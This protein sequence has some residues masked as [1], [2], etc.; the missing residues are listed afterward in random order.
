MKIVAK[1]SCL[2]NPFYQFPTTFHEAFD[3]KG[4]NVWASEDNLKDTLGAAAGAAQS[5]HRENGI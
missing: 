1:V 4:E 2:G 3:A 5:R